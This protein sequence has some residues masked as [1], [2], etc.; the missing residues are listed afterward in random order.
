MCVF[1]RVCRAMSAG[2]TDSNHDNSLHEDEEENDLEEQETLEEDNVTEPIIDELEEAAELDVE[3]A[4]SIMAVPPKVVPHEE[5]QL[6]VS[7]SPAFHI[8][9]TVSMSAA[10]RFFD[11][12]L[13]WRKHSLFQYAYIFMAYSMKPSMSWCDIDGTSKH[14]LLPT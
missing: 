2:S 13:C 6:E 7:S 1:D 9:D 14:G 11:D 12:K 5:N 8:L 4:L 3:R 10:L